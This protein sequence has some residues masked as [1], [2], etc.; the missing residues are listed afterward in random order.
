MDDIAIIDLDLKKTTWSRVHSAMRTLYVKL[1]AEPD[2]DWIRFFREERESRVVVKRHGLWIEDGYIVFDC[3]LPDVEAHHLP[4]FRRSIDYANEKYR[5]LKAVRRKESRKRQ[6]DA[7][8]EQEQL[9]MLRAMIRKDE[10]SATPAAGNGATANGA[11]KEALADADAN[12][13]FDVKRNELRARFRA[14]L[15]SRSRESD[16]G[17]D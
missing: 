5:E 15:K 7:H 10:G 9:A 3:L 1:S 2:L 16:R 12:A 17:N 11:A 8:S 14:A 6:V 13:V 4:D